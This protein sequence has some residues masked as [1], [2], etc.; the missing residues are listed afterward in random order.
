ML[1]LRRTCVGSLIALP[2]DIFDGQA[3]IRDTLSHVCGKLD[4]IF[5][6][7]VFLE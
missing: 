7:I 6:A 2:L 5:K 3:A 4:I 1:I